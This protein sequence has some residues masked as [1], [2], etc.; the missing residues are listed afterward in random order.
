[1]MMGLPVVVSDLDVNRE[2]IGDAGIFLPTDNVDQW[3]D[4]LQW[5][6]EHDNIRRE[7]GEQARNR[8]T[9]YDLD[10]MVEGYLHHLFA[11]R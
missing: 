4:T 2:I 5:L 6:A 3:R 1:M 11:E 10:Q 8:A 9:L 7:L